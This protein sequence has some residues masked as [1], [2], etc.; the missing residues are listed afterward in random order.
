MVLRAGTTAVFAADGTVRYVIAKPLP[1][2]T[3]Q[4][5]RYESQQELAER[6]VQEFRRYV[7]ALDDQ[8]SLS[9]WGNEKYQLNRMTRRAQF[10]AAHLGRPW[11]RHSDG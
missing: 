2:R 3:Q 8:D 1:W 9:V 6:R 7:Q 10:T 11:G 4:K 5:L